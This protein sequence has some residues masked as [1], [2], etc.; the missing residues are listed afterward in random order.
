MVNSET[1]RNEIV[2]GTLEH[3]DLFLARTGEPDD[4]REVASDK[5]CED[6][7]LGARIYAGFRMLGGEL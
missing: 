5:V 4:W 1:T 6:R 3:G 7:T 2:D